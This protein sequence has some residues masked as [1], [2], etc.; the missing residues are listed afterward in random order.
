M[1]PNSSTTTDDTFLCEVCHRNV[2]LMNELV[3]KARCK[4]NSKSPTE[5]TTS[6]DTKSEPHIHYA[7]SSSSSS[8]TNI[9]LPQKPVDQTNV[10]TCS[11]CTLIN[12]IANINC[13]ACGAS[14]DFTTAASSISAANDEW[15][16]NACTFSNSNTV[17]LCSMCETPRIGYGDDDSALGTA[18]TNTGIRVDRNNHQNAARRDGS[19]S[20]FTAVGPMLY[21]PDTLTPSSSNIETE[22]QNL[23]SSTMMGALA[24]GALSTLMQRGNVSAGNSSG[25]TLYGM[26]L[27]AGVGVLGGMLYNMMSSSTATPSETPGSSCNSQTGDNDVRTTTTSS[28]SSSSSDSSSGSN[29]NIINLHDTGA[30]GSSGSNSS[31]SGGRRNALIRGDVV[32]SNPRVITY[33]LFG[34][35]LRVEY[36]TVELHPLSDEAQNSRGDEEFFRRVHNAINNTHS[37]SN[38][39]NGLSEEHIQRL[40]THIVTDTDITCEKDCTCNICLDN[41][42]LGETIKVLPCLHKFHDRCIDRWLRISSSCPL[43]K[44]VV[45]AGS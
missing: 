40:H 29:T 41:F 32:G 18:A 24:G 36:S 38:G 3:H 16:C 1:Q 34:S 43:C 30:S 25:G 26:L 33:Q 27:G 28:S 19:S 45:S 39:R 5:E 4:A 15:A 31:S 37:S 10:W 14:F 44:H 6:A 42:V 12:P 35:T 22:L 9:N 21:S 7:S 17:A 8:S 2:P 23:Q 11:K 20:G 13:D